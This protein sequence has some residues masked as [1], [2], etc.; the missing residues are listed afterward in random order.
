LITSASRGFKTS[1][2]C[3]LLHISGYDLPLHDLNWSNFALVKVKVFLCI[4]ARELICRLG[5]LRSPNM[6][7]VTTCATCS[8]IHDN[9]II[10]NSHQT[11]NIKT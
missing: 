3:W 8:K 9:G 10:Q 11:R 6:S 1:E 2:V 7:S 4:G 5:I